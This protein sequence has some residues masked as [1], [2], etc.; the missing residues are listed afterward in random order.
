MLVLGASGGTIA[1]GALGAVASLRVL[2]VGTSVLEDLGLALKGLLGGGRAAVESAAG[3][4]KLV[5][6]HGGLDSLG[7]ESG[8]LLDA[9]VDGRSGVDDC[10]LNNLTL[11]DGLDN[12]VDVVVTSLLGND[13]T[14]LGAALAGQDMAAVLELGMLLVEQVLD[15]LLVAAAVLAI[16]G[17]QGA[18]NVLLGE[19]LAVGHRLDTS[20]IVVLVE[21]PLELEIGPLPLGGANPLLHN[22]RVDKLLNLGVASSDVGVDPVADLVVGGLRRLLID[23]LGPLLRDNGLLAD[24]AMARLVLANLLGRLG[25]V[26]AELLVLA[27]A[28][29]VCQAGLVLILQVALELALVVGNVAA[30]LI[31]LAG[32]I[33]LG[34]TTTVNVS[35]I[36]RECLIKDLRHLLDVVPARLGIALSGVDGVLDR[37][38]VEGLVDF[39]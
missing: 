15:L 4:V 12:L 13:V 27:G 24:C 25:P 39:S 35:L 5:E 11:E 33:L 29:V 8:I 10:G 21:L 30:G 34:I 7:V 36:F 14:V 9:L 19:N 23:K 1:G 20:L 38:H 18:V 37:L 31:N 2:D 26:G 3:S 17:G 32:G 16:L 22:G 28:L 6:S